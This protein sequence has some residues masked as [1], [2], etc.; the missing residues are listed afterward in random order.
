MV[1]LKNPQT[2]DVKV[3]RDRVRFFA[4]IF[5][6]LYFA[7]MGIW[8]HF[9]SYAFIFAVLF[10]IGIRIS[11]MGFVEFGDSFFGYSLGVLHVTYAFS[12]K[13]IVVKSYLR[14]G[15]VRVADKD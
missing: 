10:L 2:D 8:R 4:T 14:K 6:I 15:W 3:I 13:K 11:E 1:I 7:Y 5:G 12:A 9:F